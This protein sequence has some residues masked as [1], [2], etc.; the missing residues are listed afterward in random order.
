M[1]ATHNPGFTSALSLAFIIKPLYAP[2]IDNHNCRP[3]MAIGAFDLVLAHHKLVLHHTTAMCSAWSQA[4]VLGVAGGDGSHCDVPGNGFVNVCQRHA[5]LYDHF[6]KLKQISLWQAGV[7][8]L[9]LASSVQDVAVDGMCVTMMGGRSSLGYAN[10]AQVRAQSFSQS[11]C[12]QRHRHQS[13]LANNDHISAFQSTCRLS[14]S[15]RACLWAAR[16]SG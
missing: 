16:C 2:A 3:T 9:N 1:M 12:T 13:D 4:P 6:F 7:F 5:G 15:R 10:V 11:S 14:A 8:L